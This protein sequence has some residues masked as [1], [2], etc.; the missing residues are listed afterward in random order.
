LLKIGKR[1]IACPEIIDGKTDPQLME[2]IKNVP[3]VWKVL[4]RSRLE[5]FYL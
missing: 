5:N 4:R 3:K 1:G 2:R